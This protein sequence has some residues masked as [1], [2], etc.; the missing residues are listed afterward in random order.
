RAQPRVPG[1]PL[2]QVERSFGV[3]TTFARPVP[4]APGGKVVWG[5]NDLRASRTPCARWKGRL[6]CKRPSRSAG[7]QRLSRT[8]DTFIELLDL[9]D[10]IYP[11]GSG[12]IVRYLLCR[13]AGPFWCGRTPG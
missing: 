9:I 12:H 8:S 1:P 13:Q 5:A 7:P 6:G 11:P 10:A 4:P 2:R 3:Q